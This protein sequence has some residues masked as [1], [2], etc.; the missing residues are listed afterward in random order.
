M[1]R[2]WVSSFRDFYVV[3]DICCEDTCSQTPGGV[4]ACRQK[5]VCR[6]GPLKVLGAGGSRD[7]RHVSGAPTPHFLSPLYSESSLFFLPGLSLETCLWSGLAVRGH[8]A[9]NPELG[10]STGSPGSVAWRCSLE[11]SLMP[12]FLG[13]QLPA[14]RL[15][16]RSA[17]SLHGAMR[18][19][20]LSLPAASPGGNHGLSPA[21]QLSLWE[22]RGQRDFDGELDRGPGAALRVSGLGSF[23][24]KN[25]CKCTFHRERGREAD[26]AQEV[27]T[28]R[29]CQPHLKWRCLPPWIISHVTNDDALLPG[30]ASP[31]LRPAP[32]WAPHPS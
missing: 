14:G 32:L 30:L 1:S 2:K 3:Y 5:G 24:R 17:G 4:T 7:C 9:R 10:H 27:E 16:L 31:G 21:N 28:P 18:S 8:A 23:P 26:G 22:T 29:N 20:L 12:A 11:A 15:S 19:R 6:P 13:E 25:S